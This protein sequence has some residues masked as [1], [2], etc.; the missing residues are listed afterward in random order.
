[1]YISLE[2]QG[3][4]EEAEAAL[5]KWK[6]VKAQLE[7]AN[8]LL[9]AEAEHPSNDA[10]TAYKIGD[11]LLHVGQESLGLYWFS[12]ALN[13]DPQHLPTLKDLVERFESK[14]EPDKAARYR[15]QLSVLSKR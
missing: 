15:R 11:A 4:P 6:Q 7:Q 5:I 8:N 12:K 1:L 3:R 14:G 9:K 10:N 2:K 13:Y